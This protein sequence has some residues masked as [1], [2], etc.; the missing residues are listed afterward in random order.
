MSNDDP[1]ELFLALFKRAA[2]TTP[3]PDA[4]VLATVD[5]DG[6][7]SARYVLLKAV[8]QRGF[9]FYTNLNSRKAQALTAT[10]R[11]ALCFYWPGIEK[12]VRVEGTIEPVPE[13][14]ADAYFAKRPRGSQIG[15]WASDQSS[16]MDS[17]AV[18]EARVRELESRFAGGA[19]PR[20]PFWSGFRV[21]PRVIEIWTRDPSRLH[22]RDRYE[23]VGEGWVRTLLYP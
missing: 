13:E 2:E 15:A 6:Q 19:V 5:P 18:L 20:P 23:R 21:V 11:A 17:R 8:D 14:E 12:Q 3:E 22:I 16:Q 4:M 10:P 7:P 1:I 9:A